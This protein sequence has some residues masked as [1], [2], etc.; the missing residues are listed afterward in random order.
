MNTQ[1]SESK[2]LFFRLKKYGKSVVSV[3]EEN[4]PEETFKKFYDFAFPKYKGAIRSAYG[5]KSTALKLTGDQKAEMSARV[6]EI[7][8]YTLVGIGGL[9]ATYELA[10]KMNAEKREGAFVELGVARGGAA[11]LIA[12]VAFEKGA[13]ERILWLF[14]SFEGLPD[15]TA[16]DFGSD[17]ASQAKTGDH[18]RPLPKGSCLGELEEVQNLMWN[19]FKFPKEKIQFVKGWFQDTLPVTKDKLG[20]IALLRLDGDWYESTKVCLEHLYD[21]VIPGGAIIIDDYLSCFGCKKAVDEFVTNRGIKVDLTM[22]GRGGCYFL[23]P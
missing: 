15:P 21:Q 23:K 11:A 16:E 12:G 7:M 6:H 3:M 5:L 22:D 4:L 10:K 2:D 8:P 19:K 14:D 9:E 18:V 17:A 20:K 13:P 1:G